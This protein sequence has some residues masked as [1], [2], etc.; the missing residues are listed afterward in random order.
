MLT[1]I[2]A[3][4][5]GYVFS[6]KVPD[7]SKKQARQNVWP[8][9]VNCWNTDPNLEK[10]V[11]LDLKITYMESGL[12]SRKYPQWN[13]SAIDTT[14]AMFPLRIWVDGQSGEIIGERPSG[15]YSE[16]DLVK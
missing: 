5:G 12:G 6:Q 2:L 11:D 1:C 14:G 16:C 15:P 8:L 13:V 3:F 7:I 9:I 10:I 4:I